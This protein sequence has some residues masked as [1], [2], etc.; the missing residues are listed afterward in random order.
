MRAGQ[1]FTNQKPVDSVSNGTRLNEEQ[2]AEFEGFTYI[3]DA[4]NMSIADGDGT[5]EGDGAGERRK[6]QWD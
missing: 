6:S 1:A 3:P 5:G 2:Q 4:A